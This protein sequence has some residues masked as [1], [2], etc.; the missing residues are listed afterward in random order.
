MKLDRIRD[1]IDEAMRDRAKLRELADN[2]IREG[3]TLQVF[4][5]RIQP[6]LDEMGWWGISKDKLYNPVT[7]STSCSKAWQF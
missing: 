2:M 1:D 5:D 4:K 3:T 7:G 6:I